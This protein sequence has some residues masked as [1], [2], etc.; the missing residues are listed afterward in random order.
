MISF[1][2]AK[3]KKLTLDKYSSYENFSKALLNIY[4]LEKK[5]D[6]VTKWGQLTNTNVPTGGDLPIIAEALGVTV[7]DLYTNAED[8]K[9]KIAKQYQIQ[10]NENQINIPYYE[11]IYACMGGSDTFNHDESWKPLTFDIELLRRYMPGEKKFK[12]LHITNTVGDSM[13][14]TIKE[15]ELIIVTPFENDSMAIIDGAIYTMVYYGKAMVKRLEWDP[16]TG[17]VTLHSDN[18]KYS[19]IKI[20]KEDEENFKIIGR[21][22]AHFEFL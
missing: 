15:G 21:V 11:N 13:E 18:K 5:K 4:G 6:A 2:K 7:I 16:K 3:Y 19:S 10:T 12:N 8:Q 20:E 9:K 14:P 1:D 22:L 17:E